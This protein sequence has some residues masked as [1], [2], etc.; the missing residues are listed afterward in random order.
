MKDLGIRN[1]MS[2]VER[3][4]ESRNRGYERRMISLLHVRRLLALNHTEKFFAKKEF[5]SWKERNVQRCR[6]GD[7]EVCG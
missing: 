7:G 6:E 4:M 2:S 1:H 5:P 3:W